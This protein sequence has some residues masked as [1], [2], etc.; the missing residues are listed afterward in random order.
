MGQMRASGSQLRLCGWGGGVSWTPK[1][2]D[3]RIHQTESRQCCFMLCK[4]LNA[5]VPWARMMRNNVNCVDFE[6]WHFVSRLSAYSL[7]SLGSRQSSREC[8]VQMPCFYEGYNQF[9]TFWAF[10]LRNVNEAVWWSSTAG[11]FFWTTSHV[12]SLLDWIK[13]C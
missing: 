6:V 8:S 5:C 1:A 10:V 7:A 4:P 3:I 13:S 2:S 9:P 11:V 12:S